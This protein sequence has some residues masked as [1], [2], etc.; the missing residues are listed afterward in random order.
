MTSKNIHN[1]PVCLVDIGAAGGI[2]SRWAKFKKIHVLG[3]EP[4][5]RTFSSLPVN[6]NVSWFNTAL[7]NKKGKFP[8]YITKASTNTSMIKPNYNLINQLAYNNDD[9]NILT[10]VEVS[11]DTLDSVCIEN[12]FHPDV[13]K[14]D[15]QGTELFILEGA[16]KCLND[17]LFAIETEVEF[18]PLYEGQPLFTDIH[19]FMQDHNYQLMDYGN[20]LHVKGKNTSGMGGAKS[21]LISGDA[22]YFK[23]IDDVIKNIL[24]GKSNLEAIIGICSS[25]GY[26]DYA[27][28]VC[29]RLLKSPDIAI[30]EINHYIDL[31]SKQTSITRKIINMINFSDRK[32]RKYSKFVRKLI[33]V[34]H[35]SWLPG[36]G[37]E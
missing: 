23:N 34:K 12:N 27:I 15:T 3:F 5:E 14:I 33:P 11:C 16:S 8:L 24:S 2:H 20:T 17:S 19:N 7:T 13:I 18:L 21:N 9:F 1:M 32:I 31:L 35:A 26:N 4:D 25:Y 36:L 10:T 30:D 29:L 28:E 6:K 22:L 37:N